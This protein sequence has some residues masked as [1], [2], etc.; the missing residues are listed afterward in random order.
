MYDVL[1]SSLRPHNAASVP[2]VKASLFKSVSHDPRIAPRGQ[3]I[4]QLPQEKTSPIGYR[5]TTVGETITIG[6]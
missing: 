3:L 4:E 5:Y 2:A 6:N 1:R